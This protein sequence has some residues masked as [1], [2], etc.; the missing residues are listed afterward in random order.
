MHHQKLQQFKNNY[1]QLENYHIIQHRDVTLNTNKTEPFIQSN[2]NANYAELIYSITFPI[3]AM[4]E[5]IPKSPTLYNYF[6]EEQTE[7]ND[8]LLYQTQQQDPVLRQHLHWKHYKNLPPTSSL[9]IRAKEDY[10]SF[11]DVF[12]I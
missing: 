10:Y 3:P 7:I 8:T 12:K 2:H 9:T 6:Y 5:F 1:S 11:I 4:D